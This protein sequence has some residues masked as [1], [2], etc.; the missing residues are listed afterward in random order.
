MV[1]MRSDGWFP[2]KPFVRSM[3]ACVPAWLLMRSLRRTHFVSRS[4]TWPQWTLGY[5]RCEAFGSS[6][7]WLPS[8]TPPCLAMALEGV[9]LEGVSALFKKEKG[10][11]VVVLLKKGA[12][13]ATVVAGL[14]C[15]LSLKGIGRPHDVYCVLSSRP[16]CNAVAEAVK[17]SGSAEIDTM[18]VDPFWRPDA[19]GGRVLLIPCD[20]LPGLLRHEPWFWTQPEAIVIADG[21]SCLDT[22]TR[23]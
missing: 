17:T 19:R 15:R 22:R 21:L 18:V 6:A 8:L 3:I 5:Q 11:S 1:V 23:L 2:Q 14:L 20:L 16:Q 10:A 7:H 9:A 12:P 13:P 4:L